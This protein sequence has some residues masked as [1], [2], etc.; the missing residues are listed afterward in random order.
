MN[1]Y[2]LITNLA[3]EDISN[4]VEFIAVDNKSASI[5]IVDDF[6]KTFELL[7]NFPETGSIKNDINDKTV[8][9]YTMKKNFAIVYRIL[10]DKIE[11]LR[12]LTRYQN[13]F[14]IL[15]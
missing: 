15:N 4:I 13:I 5:K 2:V 7:S 10:N 14:A 6:Y 3:K 8:R 1:K 9:I 12:V 11:I